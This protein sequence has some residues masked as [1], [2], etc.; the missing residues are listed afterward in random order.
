M[1]KT[2]TAIAFLAIFLGSTTAHAVVTFDWARVGNPGNPPDQLYPVSNPTNLR[3]GAVGY[4]YRISKHEVTNAQYTAFLNAVDPMGTNS[5]GLYNSLMRTDLRGGIALSTGA[6]NGAKYSTKTNMGSK[7]LNY[8]SFFDAMRFVNWLENGQP[9]GGSGT[10]TG[11]YTIADGVN[12]TRAPG[13]TFFIPS[14]D[15]WY[16]AAYYQ[17]AAQGGDADNYWLYPTAS[18][19]APTI[20]TANAVGDISNPGTNVANYNSGADWNGLDGNVTTV[21]S[22]GPGSA[23]F[24]GTFDQGGNVWEWNDTVTNIFGPDR[25]LRGGDMFSFSFLFAASNRNAIAPSAQSYD[26]GFRVASIPEPSA[27]I[28]GALGMLTVLQRRRRPSSTLYILPRRRAVLFRGG[29]SCVVFRRNDSP[30]PLFQALILS[31]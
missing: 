13:A 26:I 10:E 3:F 21:G 22:A 29:D 4:T 6:A 11:V 16:K 5:L 7:P 12:A 24:Y 15:E 8:V 2:N 27:S 1:M 31:L 14:E 20:A 25:G 9:T 17:P 18:N 23:S 28:L 19:A 30:C